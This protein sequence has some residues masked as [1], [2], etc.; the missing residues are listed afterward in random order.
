MSSK[1]AVKILGNPMTLPVLMNTRVQ[2]N[3]NNTY[4]YSHHPWC[5]YCT[6]D[7]ICYRQ[8]SYMSP[9]L[10]GNKIVD[11]SHVVGVPPTGASPTTY[12]FSKPK[13]IVRRDDKLIFFYSVPPIL[14]VLR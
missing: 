4:C 10:V 6:V 8:A 12:S 9:T 2:H 3:G 14:N 5:I 13:I 11:H 1:M 7:F